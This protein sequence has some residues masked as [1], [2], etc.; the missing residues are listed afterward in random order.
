MFRASSLKFIFFHGLPESGIRVVSDVLGDFLQRKIGG[1][2]KLV[3]DVHSDGNEFVT[4]GVSCVSN[5]QPF[6]LSWRQVKCICKIRQVNVLPIIQGEKF[7]NQE[8]VIDNR[9]DGEVL[10]AEEATAEQG[11]VSGYAGVVAG[12]PAGSDRFDKV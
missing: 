5:D 9:T 10:V 12:L 3:C 8:T 6:S 4:E 7:L 2:E 11:N 1:V